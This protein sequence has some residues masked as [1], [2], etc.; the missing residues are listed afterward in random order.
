MDV[1]AAFN[2]MTREKKRKDMGL[3]AFRIWIRAFLKK[4]LKPE[5]YILAA[6]NVM[7]IQLNKQ[8]RVA[9]G[10]M[11]DEI[12]KVTEGGDLS[13]ESPKKMDTIIKKHFPDLF[14]NCLNNC[15]EAKFNIYCLYKHKFQTF[16]DKRMWVLE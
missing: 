12:L 9:L 13:L 16:T 2:R 8:N 10:K 11:V 1:A 3:E 4:L 6:S 15:V 14:R 7:D 5:Y